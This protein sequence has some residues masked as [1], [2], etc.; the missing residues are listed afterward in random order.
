MRWRRPSDW[1]LMEWGITLYVTLLEKGRPMRCRMPW[2]HCIKDFLSIRRCNWRRRWD[3]H[4]GE[5]GTQWSISIKA[6]RSLRSIGHCRINNSTYKDGEVGLE[7]NFR[8]TESICLKYLGKREI[9]SL[10]RNVGCSSTGWDEV[11]C[12]QVKTWWQKQQWD[13]AQGG[14]REWIPCIEGETIVLSSQEKGQGWETW[15]TG[16]YHK[17]RGR[18]FRHDFLDTS[19]EKWGD[20]VL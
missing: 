10:G 11:R 7:F 1:F 12:S 16:F 8:I 4:D 18:G 15:S 19:R 6:S 2:L 5:R 3:Q 14:G 17:Y 13:K 9:S 20:L